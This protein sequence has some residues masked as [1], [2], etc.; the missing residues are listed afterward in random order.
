MP[1][2]AAQ[3]HS[4]PPGGLRIG[5]VAGEP[6]GDLLGAG[7][8]RALRERYPD[9]ALAGVAGPAMQAE[10]V[11]SWAPLEQLSVMGLAEVIR[12][13][14]GLFALRRGLLGAFER[15]RP[16]VVIGIDA[17]DF[18]LGLERRLRQ[19]G[20]RTM[21]YVSPSIWA[22]RPGRVHTV[23]RAAD[24]VLCLLPFEPPLYREHGVAARFVGHPMADAIAPVTDRAAARAALGLEAGEASWVALLPASRHGEVERLGGVIAGAAALL[25]ARQ[26]GIRFI[27]P[28]A[29]PALREQ[30]AAQLAR[31]APGAAVRLVDGRSREVM[32]AADLVVLASGTATLEAALLGRPMVVAYR[33]A[34]ATARLVRA[35]GLLSTQYF[36]LPNLLAGESLVPELIQEQA[37][38]E[39]IAGAAAALLDDPARCAALQARFGEMHALL[40]RDADRCAAE[41][42]L[43]MAGR[44]PPPSLQQE[45]A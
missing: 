27:A 18:N 5:L 10:G 15:F 45:P 4:S 31:H 22:W 3:S 41:A 34:P 29:T 39:G 32:A 35:L 14:P 17:P 25:A 36:A 38:P 19:R 8:A 43:A 12:H 28:M 44:V 1:G 24:E 13:L 33:V 20:M 42:V 40:R 11:R 21:H 23:A 16:H 9:A 30:F 26:P 6:S 7:L 2:R 37:T